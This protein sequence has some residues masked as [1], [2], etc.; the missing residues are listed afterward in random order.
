MIFHKSVMVAVTAVVVA[1]SACAQSTL[2]ELL[3]KGAAKISKENWQ[4]Q[5]P[6]SLGGID[7]TERVDFSFTFKAD[8]TFS[9][10]AASLRGHGTSG[11][12][13]HMDDGPKWKAMH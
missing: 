3:D 7:F 10:S 13:W 12:R 1:G 4:S 6:S 9:G 11:S 8:G 5:L 2:G